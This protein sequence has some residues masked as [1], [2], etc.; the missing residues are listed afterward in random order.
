MVTGA[1]V[2][3]YLNVLVKSHW[4][5]HVRRTTSEFFKEGRTW[6][7]YITEVHATSK[8]G[9]HF[10]DWESDRVILCPIFLGSMDCGHFTLLVIDRT[11]YSPGFF[12]FF[13]SLPSY[14]K[15]LPIVHYEYLKTTPMW[16]DGQSVFHALASAGSMPKQGSGTNDCAVYTCCIAAAYMRYLERSNAFQQLDSI[17]PGQQGTMHIKVEYTMPGMQSTTWGD[18]GRSHIARTLEKSEV[19]PQDMA[20]HCLSVQLLDDTRA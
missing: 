11:R 7:D 17:D 2:R 10:I 1:C 5:R 18:Y 13:D 6:N 4:D 15:R 20:M 9:S 19:D 3:A 8:D 12:W 14:C 16:Q